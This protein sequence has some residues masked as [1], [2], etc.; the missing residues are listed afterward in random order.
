MESVNS[1]KYFRSTRSEN[2]VKEASKN[3]HSFIIQRQLKM[4]KQHAASA[5]KTTFKQLREMTGS[6]V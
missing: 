5:G 1:P 3:G 4:L 6:K 2:A